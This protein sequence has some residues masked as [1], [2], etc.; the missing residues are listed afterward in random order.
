MKHLQVGA[1][2]SSSGGLWKA[3]DRAVAIEAEALQI[4]PSAPQNWRPTNH[5]PEAYLK[6][7][8]AHAAAG[9]G[10]VWAHC[11]YL[12]NL[13]TE[14]EEQ[15]EKSVAAVVNALT[16][17]ERAGARGVVLH[18]GSHK[19]AG[20]ESALSQVASAIERIFEGAPGDTVL[21]LEN[22]AGHGGTIGRD[23]PE[24]GTVL[25]AVSNQRL[26]VCVD[27]CHAF[28]GGYNL[29]TPDGVQA[30]LEEFD[31]EV[32]LHN[33]AVWH[34]NDSKMGL[35]DQRDRHANIGEGH[36]GTEGFRVWL[37]AI[38]R[39]PQITANAML[40]EVPGFGDD[41]PDLENVRR[42]KAIRAEVEGV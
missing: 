23:F 15:L 5:T 37:D 13:A 3:V 38:R 41:G 32:G 24:L 19:G 25:R 29:A 10:E 30:M 26:Q 14:S 4:F 33:L 9:L 28:A 40:L 20:L 6:F 2:V 8:E 18:T 1:H 36:I 35:G 12:V 42:M 21:A 17:A 31:R 11:I 39:V 7:R 22:A 16:V 34:L 27:T